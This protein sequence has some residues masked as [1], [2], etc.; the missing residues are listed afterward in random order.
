[1]RILSAADS[2]S[3]RSLVRSREQRCQ[4]L[5]N[6]AHTCRDSRALPSIRWRSVPDKPWKLTLTC[7]PLHVPTHYSRRTKEHLVNRSSRRPDIRT[8]IDK[9]LSATLARSQNFRRSVSP[10]AWNANNKTLCTIRTEPAKAEV[11][12]DRSTRRRERYVG[13]HDVSWFD[14]K[15]N[16]ANVVKIPQRVNQV[17][18]EADQS[19]IRN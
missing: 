6:E 7:M 5:S 8:T 10:R 2:S 16:V 9:R 15:V 13:E 17:G 18:G 12:Q 4:P 3:L 14:V 11:A 19:A 1:M